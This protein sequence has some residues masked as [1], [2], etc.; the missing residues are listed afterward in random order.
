MERDVLGRLIRNRLAAGSLPR[1]A[2]GA[3]SQTN[4]SHEVCDG[5]TQPVSPMEVLYRVYGAGY[6][7]FHF[8]RSCFSVW[9]GECAP[10]LASRS[11]QTD[12]A[13]STP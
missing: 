9:R 12:W 3:V 5:C 13:L 8:H 7:R 6:C 4:G 2:L 1:G 10:T 11:K